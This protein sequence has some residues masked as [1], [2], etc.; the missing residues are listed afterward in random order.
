MA[1]AVTQSTNDNRLVREQ[2]QAKAEAPKLPS[3]KFTIT[4]NI[5][6][7]NLETPNKQNLPTFWHQWAN[8]TKHQEMLVLA[9]LLMSY[10]RGPDSFTISTPVLSSKI[11]QDLLAFTFVGDSPEDLKTGVHPFVIAE[12]SAEHW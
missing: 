10:A 8:C 7:E 6:L 5:L 9:E 2:K 3:A 4:L 1:V 12:G 11:A